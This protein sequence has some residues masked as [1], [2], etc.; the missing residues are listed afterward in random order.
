MVPRTLTPLDGPAKAR[1]TRPVGGVPKPRPLS[2]DA[3]RRLDARIAEIAARM[4]Q[5]RRRGRG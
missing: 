1:G 4:A 3:R 5:A 2:R